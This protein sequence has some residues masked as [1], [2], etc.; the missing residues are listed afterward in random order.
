[1][2]NY[3]PKRPSG[4]PLH[5]V[6][7]LYDDPVGFVP[8][9]YFK[10]VLLYSRTP[11]GGCCSISDDLSCSYRSGVVWIAG[12]EMAEKVDDKT[13]YKFTFDKKKTKVLEKEELVGKALLKVL[14]KIEG[15]LCHEDTHI[16]QCN[17]KKFY[18]TEPGIKNKITF[19]YPEYFDIK[20]SKDSNFLRYHNTQTNAQIACICTCHI[21]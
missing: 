17:K 18:I 20:V 3:F 6:S 9:P 13:I 7:K 1:M 11:K 14:D 10:N 5:T 12:V 4:A 8:P 16:V 2:R 19:D 21:P 15:I